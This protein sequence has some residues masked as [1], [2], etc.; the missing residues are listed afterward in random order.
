VISSTSETVY[1]DGKYLN[2]K[3]T[4]NLSGDNTLVIDGDI[5]LW[6]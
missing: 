4:L 2:D 1:K 5:L 6:S 3:L